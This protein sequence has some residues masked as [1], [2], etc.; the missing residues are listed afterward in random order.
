MALDANAILHTLQEGSLKGGFTMNEFVELSTKAMALPT[1]N[2][3]ELAKLL[4]K[5]ISAFGRGP[6]E[7][8]S[9]A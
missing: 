4:I 2:K 5:C 3:A 8:H 7:F 6:G 9:P 1:E